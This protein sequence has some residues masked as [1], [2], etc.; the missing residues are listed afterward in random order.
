MAAQSPN[1]SGDYKKNHN[2]MKS[3]LFLFLVF[4]IFDEAL[5]QDV[6][7]WKVRFQNVYDETKC[8]ANISD[9][10]WSYS[11]IKAMPTLWYTVDSSDLYQ[12][13]TDSFLVKVEGQMKDGKREGV[14]I[15]SLI[16]K[17]AQKLI[18]LYEQTFKNDELTGLWKSYSLNGRLVLSNNYL[19]GR[20]IGL[21]QSFRADGRT[22]LNETELNSDDNTIVREFYSSG[23]LMTETPYLRGKT[24]GVGKKFYENGK[25]EDRIEFKYGEMEGI[26]RYYH[27]NGQLW[28]E[29]QYFADRPWT[30]L[31]NYDKNGKKRE[32]GTLNDGT[33]SIIFYN[34]DNTIREVLNYRNGN[35]IQ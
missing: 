25:L 16:E 4:A 26:R 21:Q 6:E 17:K 3:I 34:D 22:L 10:E 7:H 18:R 29:Q 31:G 11:F 9:N 12:K 2:L 1:V 13:F 35:L 20:Q 19:K 15:Y 23:K 27:D 8:K 14:F 28:A 30:I 24:H 32:G 5:S 33:G